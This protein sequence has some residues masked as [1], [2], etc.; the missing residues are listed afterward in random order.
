MISPQMFENRIIN[1]AGKLGKDVCKILAAALR[2]VDPYDCVQAHLQV[3]KD[4]IIIGNREILRKDIERIFLLGFGKAS[5]PM[6]KAVIDLLG[7]DLYSADVI[8]KDNKFQEFE[9]YGN[10]LRIQFGGHPVPTAESVRS[11]QSLLDAIPHLTERD[12]VLVLI[13]GGGSALFTAPMGDVELRDYQKMTE[14]LLRS[15]ADINEIN[16]LRKHI[17]QVKGGRLAARLAPARIHTLVLS[18]V[19]GDGLD[20]IASGPTVPDPT[21]F[22]DAWEIINKHHLEKD[23]PDSILQLILSGLEGGVPETLKE[24]DFIDLRV[25]HHLVGTNSMAALAARQKARELA[26][27]AE[28]ISTRVTGLTEHVAEFMTGIIQTEYDIKRPLNSP[29][30]LIFGGET[31]VKVTGDGRGG[32]NQDLVLRAVQRLDGLGKLLFISL[33]TDGEDGPTD[34]AGAASDAIVF[35]DGAEMFGLSIATD[36]NTN[37]SYGYFEKTGGL[38]KTGSTGTNVN[39]LMIIIGE[40]T[41]A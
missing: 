34:A 40:I 2:A 30:C 33:A 25:D 13:S 12:L 28:V 29:F 16:T 14:A 41:K 5:V 10:L 3:K 31:T 36:I 26:Y 17:D 8:T 24:E 15:G 37:N 9:G 32:R 27:N 19:I 39:D 11:T 20:M 6:A 23:L 35:R 4:K 18:D 1:R 38:I 22:H 21:T 7:E